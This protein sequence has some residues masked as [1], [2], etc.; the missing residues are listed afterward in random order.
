MWMWTSVENFL[1]ILCAC[2]PALKP[3]FRRY[4]GGSGASRR[5]NNSG[6]LNTTPRHLRNAR[7]RMPPNTTSHISGG[8]AKNGPRYMGHGVTVTTELDVLEH[9]V[10]EP[11]AEDDESQMGKYTSSITSTQDLS[12]HGAR[13][14][15]SPVMVSHEM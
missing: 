11:Y 1:A 3:F 2:G 8:N 5:G 12:R 6:R 15:K 4:L 9:G 7:G 14:E 10:N 13:I